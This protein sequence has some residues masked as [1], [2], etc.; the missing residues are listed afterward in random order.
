MTQEFKILD[1]EVLE[2]TETMTHTRRKQD[3]ENEKADHETEI[4]KLND[5]LSLFGN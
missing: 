1:K 2:V 4:A 3:L 5:M